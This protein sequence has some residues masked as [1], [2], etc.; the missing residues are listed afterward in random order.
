MIKVKVIAPFKI[1]GQ[2][3]DGSVD[4]PDHTR[5]SGLLKLGRAPLFTRLLPVSVNGEQVSGRRV[6]CD[7]DLVIFIVPISGG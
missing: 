6:L 2:A 7:G 4:L 1:P 3:V 5:V